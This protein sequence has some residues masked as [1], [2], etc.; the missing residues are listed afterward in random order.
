MQVV[1][2][3]HLE[4]NTLIVGQQ[5]KSGKFGVSNDPILM[6]M[7]STKFYSNPLKTM[8]QETLFNAY[9]AHKMVNQPDMPIDVILSDISGLSIRDYG[10]GI[11]DHMIEETYCVYGAST[12]RNQGNQTGG[13]GLGCKSPFAYTE[14]F[15]VTSFSN[16]KKNMYMFK[17]Y[18]DEN[19][20]GP[21]YKQLVS[22]LITMESGLLV[23][24]PI[25]NND[26]YTAFKYIE[27]IV[28]YSGMK[29]N[30]K[31]IFN[32]EI[33]YKVINSNNID[34]YALV[35][36]V[37]DESIIALY[38]GVKY[39]IKIQDDF[40]YIYQDITKILNLSNNSI[41]INF[42]PNTLEPVPNREAINFNSTSN[43][44]ILTK[45]EYIYENFQN[46]IEKIFKLYV[47]N[48][49]KFIKQNNYDYTNAKFIYYNS[50]NKI[51]KKF[52]ITN[53]IDSILNPDIKNFFISYLHCNIHSIHKKY[54]KY[55]TNQFNKNFI[56]FNKNNTSLETN[57]NSFIFDLVKLTNK[58]TDEK[59]KSLH[60]Y[61]YNTNSKYNKTIIHIYNKHVKLCLANKRYCFYS[62]FLSFAK[63]RVIIS[64]TQSL[65]NNNIN[66]NEVNKQNKKQYF[67][68][69][70][71]NDS[72]YC[73]V[74]IV[75]TNNQENHSIVKSFFENK[76]YE[77][78]DTSRINFYKPV[79]LKKKIKNVSNKK[80]KVGYP[81]AKKDMNRSYSHFA[82][83]DTLIE[84]PKIYVYFTKKDI[85]K[86]NLKE[87]NSYKKLLTF[88]FKE[89]IVYINNIKTV[90]KLRK[91][92]A[93][94][95]SEVLELQY[96]KIY[97]NKKQL[98]KVVKF[99]FN[100]IYNDLINNSKYNNIFTKNNKYYKEITSNIKEPFK[101]LN[102]NSSFMETI[103]KLDLISFYKMKL[104]FKEYNTIDRLIKKYNDSYKTKISNYI[105]I[106]F[107]FLVKLNKKTYKINHQKYF[108]LLDF[109]NIGRAIYN[110]KN[111]ITKE[112]YNELLNTVYKISLI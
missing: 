67:N 9:D 37:Y 33:K 93:I 68:I 51:S 78:I 94:S 4:D 3:D 44:Y 111:Q 40:R 77:V 26:F 16:N 48:L 70:K 86:H 91:E 88:N 42:E 55:I 54:I 71:E 104:F 107:N 11:P 21:G 47:K 82:D 31:T 12:K 76:G 50:F 72:N 39:P 34:S 109:L 45:L 57:Y 64:K 65:V 69:V 52:L 73:N 84:N 108:A 28:L 20:G 7:L 24:I 17:R 62:D 14:N 23:N 101:V 63:K 112:D 100:Q 61:M 25:L 59:L 102:L 30:V 41:I 105:Y 22:N 58:N 56:K 66:F 2:P 27:E 35:N 19:N 18:S 32:K 80:E 10:P 98:K 75:I 97:N 60:F 5:F 90:E 8:I 89:P 110:E 36:S 85:K 81:L 46:N 53:G 49:I 106:Y 1:N 79:K 92:G 95:V 74:P 29:V 15:T 83:Y 13:F 6:S 43:K 96:K 87:Y 38:G 99:F 103:D